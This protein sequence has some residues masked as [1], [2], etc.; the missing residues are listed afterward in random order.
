MNDVPLESKLPDG[1]E[2]SS[3][4]LHL[5]SCLC[6]ICV[7][8][9]ILLQRDNSKNWRVSFACRNPGF[10]PVIS[11]SLSTRG[12][13]TTSPDASWVSVFC[14]SRLWALNEKMRGWERAWNT[15]TLREWT[16]Y[17]H[18]YGISG[19]HIGLWRISQCI[20]NN[21]GAIS[22]FLIPL[23]KIPV[24]SHVFF[25]TLH[26]HPP[27]PLHQTVLFFLLGEQNVMWLPS[28]WAVSFFLNTWQVVE[29][30]SAVEFIDVW[31]SR[32]CTWPSM[33]LC[34]ITT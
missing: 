10:T 8:K 22:L 28:L 1:K 32:C 25:P 17:L 26:P 31:I 7:K 11:G 16:S 9:K 12:R 2:Y 30:I 4:F 3:H 19:F 21:H 15:V 34:G 29:W 24:W 18:A 33:D 14:F 23:V 5:E 6:I 13:A 27:L 20:P